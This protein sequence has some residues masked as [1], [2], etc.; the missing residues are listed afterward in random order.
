MTEEGKLCIKIQWPT[1]PDDW[2][3]YIVK[4]GDRY[5]GYSRL[6]E[7]AQGMEFEFSK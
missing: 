7:A 3:R 1:N 6:N 2:C 5:Y 4:A